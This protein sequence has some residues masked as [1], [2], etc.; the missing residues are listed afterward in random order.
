MTDLTDL[1]D[2]H[3]YNV[4]DYGLDGIRWMRDDGRG[5]VDKYESVDGIFYYAYHKDGELGSWQYVFVG[6]KNNV[7]HVN[8]RDAM[9]AV[10]REC[11][12][13]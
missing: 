3:W 13:G 6:E 8:L 10:D 5:L 12:R 11:P 4:S 1:L 2:E 7:A 9:E